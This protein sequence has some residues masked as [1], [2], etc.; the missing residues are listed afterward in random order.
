MK[1][2]KLNDKK[3]KITLSLDDLKSNNASKDDFLYNSI[4]SQNLI[5]TIL[6]R[7]NTEINFNTNNSRLIVEIFFSSNEEYIFTIT[8]FS[9]NDL[10]LK[11]NED[12]F[13]Y[14]FYCF[15]D[16]ISLCKYIKNISNFN[17][18]NFFKKVKLYSYNNIYY[19]CLLKNERIFL[20]SNYIKNIFSEFGEYISN[21]YSFSNILKEHGKVVLDKDK[22]INFINI[23]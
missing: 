19:L 6:N 11:N 10:T 1:F 18:N 8:K 3:I 9:Q 17:I 16:F 2:E 5:E 13:I 22:L 20:L 21:S 23:Y 14:K 4:V 7:A 12:F 15:D